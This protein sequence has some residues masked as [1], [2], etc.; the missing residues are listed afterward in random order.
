MQKEIKVDRATGVL[1]N[2]II[3][4]FIA[5]EQSDE[6]YICIYSLRDEDVILFHHEGG[7]DIGDVDA[8]ATK[9]SIEPGTLPT[10]EAMSAALLGKVEGERKA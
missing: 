3:E 6:H 5:H 1:Q 10:E 2:F 4:P 8:K 7:V 9:M